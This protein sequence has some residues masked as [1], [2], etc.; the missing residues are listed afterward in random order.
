MSCKVEY[1]KFGH[2]GSLCGVW[3]FC[4][5]DGCGRGSDHDNEDSIWS[6]CGHSGLGLYSFSYLC[7]SLICIC[8]VPF[9]N[10]FDFQ[11]CVSVLCN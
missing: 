3:F 6:L 8:C 4:Q 10:A 1:Q 5:G 11:Y 7:P 9:L 2:L